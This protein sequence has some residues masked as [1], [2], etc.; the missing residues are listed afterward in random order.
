MLFSLPFLQFGH[1]AEFY[2]NHEQSSDILSHK[3]LLR[4]FGAAEEYA[5]EMLNDQGISINVISSTPSPIRK[6]ID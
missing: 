3:Q 4:D 1:S 2:T 5:D 6:S